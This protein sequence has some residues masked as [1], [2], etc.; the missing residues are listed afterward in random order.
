VRVRV[1]VASFPP[2]EVRGAFLEQLEVVGG[3]GTGTFA[4]YDQTGAAIHG[5]SIDPTALPSFLLGP[6]IGVGVI[7]LVRALLLRRRARG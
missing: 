7:A 5:G 1:A 4:R 2:E 3:G 6:W